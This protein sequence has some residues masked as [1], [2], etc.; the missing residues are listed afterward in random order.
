MWPTTSKDISLTFGYQSQATKNIAD[1]INIRAEDGDGVYAAIYGRVIDI[2]Y[3]NEYGNYV[4]IESENNIKIIYGHLNNT[5]IAVNDTVA[6][7]ERIGTV[8]R[9]GMG[10][11]YCLSFAVFVND[12]AV[13]PMNY[14]E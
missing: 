7:G 8:G 14:Y 3:D 10:T 4:V 12:Q 1:H 6:T 2:G 13:D 11:G 9:S 5:L